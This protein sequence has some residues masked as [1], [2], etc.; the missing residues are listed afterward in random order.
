MP[1]YLDTYGEGEEQR[2]R[3]ILRSVVS[4][5]VL[6]VVISL[7]WYLFKNHHQESIVRTFLG[8]VKRGDLAGAYRDWGCTSAKPCS[9]Y[10]FDKF[11]QDWGTTA[12][13]GAPDPA[14]L[15][16][17]DSE[18][19]GT[20]VLLTVAVNS[21]RQEKLWVEKSSD[22]ISFAPYPICPHK[23]PYAILMHRTIGKLR[24]PLL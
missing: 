16:I 23:S 24:K 18:T 9:G 21:A 12:K 1:G 7:G 4:V 14:V 17:K 3:I 2:S 15:G 10:E 19:C 5:V 11:Q 13:D 20:G 6:A 22:A 8:D